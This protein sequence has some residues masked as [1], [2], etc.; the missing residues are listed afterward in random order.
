MDATCRSAWKRRIAGTATAL[1]GLG[2]L[3]QFV[4][5]GRDHVNP[6]VHR[7]PAWDS[8]RTRELAVRACFDCHSNETR[9]PWYSHVAPVS[10]LMQRDVDRGRGELN[11]SEWD[12]RQ[13]EADDAAEEVTEGRMPP[14]AYRISH[15]EARL[16]SAEKEDLRR[17]LRASISG[18]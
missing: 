11:F 6:P 3:I 12:R 17:G 15:P 1:V 10:W 16:S 2:V 9:W 5:Y 18:N 4:P 13:E 14:R 7:E 8:G